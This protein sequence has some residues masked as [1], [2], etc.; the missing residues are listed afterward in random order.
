MLLPECLQFD[1]CQR[2]LVVEKCHSWAD[3]VAL[4]LEHLGHQVRIA[5]DAQ[6]ALVVAETFHPDVVLLDPTMEGITVADVES[7]LCDAKGNEP[8][9]VA[10]TSPF[11][12][13]NQR[14]VY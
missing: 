7:V 3:R 12:L 5:C 9:R 10:D 11:V 6:A 8:V 13:T 14:M 1:M 2:I 4:L